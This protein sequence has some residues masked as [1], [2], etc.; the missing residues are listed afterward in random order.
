MSGI[1]L[2]SPE[3]ITLVGGS[4]AA[5]RHLARALALAPTLVAADGGVAHALA[6]GH[7]PIAVIGDMDS[8]PNGET[9]RNSDI[10]MY[11]STDQD[12][13]D[14][15]KCLSSIR[16]PLILGCGFL[17]DRTD[18]ALASLS[19][20]MRYRD[21][22]VILL[23]E[24]DLAFHWPGEMAL[25][26]PPGTRVSFFPLA[27]ATGT[28]SAGLRWSVEGLSLRPGGRIGTSNEATGGEMRAAFD[29]PG[30]LALLPMDTL[31][32]VASVL[33]TRGR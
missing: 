11:P 28:V 19:A 31:D 32:Q 21:R 10:K 2:D 25:D 27:P 4:S 9:W 3:N 12:T 29:A 8:L 17:G 7:R 23:G 6:C 16:A 22:P 30:M 5:R 1:L 13:T 26:L 20:L 18:H 24:E 33:S 14:F 15:E